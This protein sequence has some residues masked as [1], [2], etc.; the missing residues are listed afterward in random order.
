M[1]LHNGWNSLGIHVDS[2]EIVRV[3]NPIESFMFAGKAVPD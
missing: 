1:V 3:F 2:L